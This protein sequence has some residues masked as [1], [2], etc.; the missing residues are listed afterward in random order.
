MSDLMQLLDYLDAKELLERYGI[1]SIESAYVESAK[2]AA[3]FS[4]GKPIVMKVLSDKQLHKSKAG[5]VK[6][7]LTTAK[8]VETAY[9]ELHKKALRLKPY[10]IIVQK[11]SEQGNEIILGG[12]TDP[13]FGKVVLIGLGGI[14]VE[15]FRDFALRVAPISRYDAKE[16][17]AQLKSQKIIT[18]D[19]K[20]TK[21]IEELLAKIAKLMQEND[22]IS[23]LDL[24]PVIITDKGYQIVDIRILKA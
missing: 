20:H 23:E 6:L 7:N 8:E 13:Q 1:H 4:K 22:S 5:L 12:R 9:N 19:G 24:N 11:M 10:K 14:Y 2:E 18:H 21:L 15:I 3:S 17:L 16:M